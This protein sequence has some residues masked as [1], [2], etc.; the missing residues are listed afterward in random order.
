[1]ISLQSSHIRTQALLTM[2]D[3]WLGT[4]NTN[5]INR[6]SLLSGSS[7]FSTLWRNIMKNMI[8]ITMRYL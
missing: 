2:H 1:M 6:K 4:G 8:S 3:M 5:M 7:N